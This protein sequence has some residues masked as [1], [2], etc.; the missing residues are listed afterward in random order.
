MGGVL[1][2]PLAA[3]ALQARAYRVGVIHQGAPCIPRPSIGDGRVSGTWDS[4]EG[5]RIVLDVRDAKAD[6]KVCE[7]LAREPSASVRPTLQPRIGAS[8]SRFVRAPRQG[9]PSLEH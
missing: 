1:A 3:E 4:R 7:R 9:A 5:K 8:A 6:L 2:A